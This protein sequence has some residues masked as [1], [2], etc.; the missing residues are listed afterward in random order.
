MPRNW[1]KSW[2][3][4]EIIIFYVPSSAALHFRMAFGIQVTKLYQKNCL[5]MGQRLKLKQTQ[6]KKQPKIRT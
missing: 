1:E 5:P 4:Y 3:K 2:L 6:T